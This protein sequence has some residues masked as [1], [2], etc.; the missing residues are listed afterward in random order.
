MKMI[1]K[2]FITIVLLSFS[3]S[4]NAQ[5]P[6]YEEDSLKYGPGKVYNKTDEAAEFLGGV[7][8][9]N[10]F[11]STFYDPYV[12]SD[13]NLEVLKQGTIAARF[14]VETNGKVKYVE[15]I[16]SLS[17]AYDEEMERTLLRMPKWKPA[18]V[19]GLPVRSFSTYRY[20][21]KFYMR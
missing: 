1:V 7:E 20:S 6:M 18:K 4:A 10:E 12:G 13:G 16:K 14:I 17:L 2:L 15:I 9:I 11:F 5:G 21:I 19:N 8:R 3:I